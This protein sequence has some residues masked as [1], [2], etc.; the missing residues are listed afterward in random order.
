MYHIVYV[1][2]LTMELASNFAELIRTLLAANPALNSLIPHHHGPVYLE[3][4]GRSE[5]ACS[6][7]KCQSMHGTPACVRVLSISRASPQHS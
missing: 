6:I 4:G 2:L 1:Y 3:A 7:A 5:P